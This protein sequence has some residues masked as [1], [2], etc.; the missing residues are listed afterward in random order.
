MTSRERIQAVLRGEPADKLAIDFGAMRSTGIHAM[1]Y[2]RL[3]KFLGL[4]DEKI[5]VYDI[6]Q[7]LADPSE[8]V[9]DLMGGDILQAHKR[10]PAFGIS[11]ESYR[12]SR[13]QDGTPCHVPEGFHP[14]EN[15]NGDLEIRDGERIIAKMPKGGFYF[16]IVDRIYENALTAEDIDRVPL[17]GLD[18][19]DIAFMEKRAGDLYENTEKAVLM[20]FGGNVFEAGQ[21]DFG[22]ENFYMN[23]AAEKDLM[24]YYFERITQQYICDLKRLMPRVQGF[25]DVIQFGDDLG[26]QIAPQ[27]SPKM[28]EEMIKPYHTRIYSFIRSNYPKVKVFLHCCGAIYDL[29]PSLIDAGVE[30]LNP[31]QISARSMEPEKL[32]QNYGKD[33]VFWGGGANMQDTVPLS[34]TDAIKKEVSELIRIFSADGGFVFN[35]VHN[36]QA[37]IPPEKIL[38]IYETAKEWRDKH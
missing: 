35:Q 2:A 11:I 37:D 32:K 19:A 38:A 24:H 6:S 16:D 34:D 12:E 15:M 26:T 9:V 5:F 13:L 29:I 14:E 8:K 31:V 18:D 27:I 1:A 7:Q 22:F 33:I 30:I 4:S 23:L 25:I 10:R 28:Y 20:E 21:T 17:S 3:L 36:I